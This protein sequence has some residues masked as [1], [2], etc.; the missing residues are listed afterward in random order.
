MAV[1]KNT[2][3]SAN[4]LFIKPKDN[5]GAW[6]IGT[7]GW[8]YPAS[9]GP[10]TW[11]GVFYPLKKTDE[12]RFYS[13]YFNTVEIN[14]TFYRPCSAKTAESWV[15]RT[16]DDFEFTIKAWQQFT[17]AR[18]PL[19][20]EEIEEFR[21]GIAPLGEAGKLGAILFQFPA[22]FHCTDDAIDRLRALLDAF[23]GYTA[24]VEL[25]HRSWGDYMDELI[26]MNAVP[27]FI[28]EPKFHDSIRQALGLHRGMLYLRFHG[29]NAG[30]WWRHEHRSER[31]DYLYSKEEIE[32][33][34]GRLKE[35]SADKI[36]RKAYIFFN[37]HPGAKAVAN[38]VLLRALLDVPVE[39]LLP[40][41]LVDAFP[42]LKIGSS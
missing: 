19:S 31:Y 18:S 42:D 7:S 41:T 29:R 35:M 15:G 5:T 39:E 4:S 3:S 8:S 25:R 37:N 10:G 1:R 38:A 12:L 16:P 6:R 24:V 17:H 36:I 40:Q 21:Q 2:A 34:A 20:R 14:S 33:Y 23:E 32:S 27:A 22:S 26:Q 13:R 9:A 30:K 11:T 28:D